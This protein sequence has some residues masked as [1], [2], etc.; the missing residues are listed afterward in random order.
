MNYIFLY[1]KMNKLNAKFR[2]HPTLGYL[3]DYE[4][5]VPV[6]YIYGTK[7]P[8]QF[9]NVQYIVFIICFRWFELLAKNRCSEN[10]GV[11]GGH[12]IMKDNLGLL[13][14]KLDER[15]QR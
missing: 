13:V 14:K 7:K 12:W 15:I 2:N 6:V 11:E 10:I 9:H 1:Y 3:H 8:F 4:P 5:S